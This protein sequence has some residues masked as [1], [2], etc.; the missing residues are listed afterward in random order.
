MMNQKAERLLFVPFILHPV[1]SV[2]RNDIRQISLFLN[3]IIILSNKIRIII[4]SLTRH[5]FPIIKTGR[6]TFQVP[7]TYQSCL[8]THLLKQLRKSLLC[9]I[10]NTGSVIIKFIGTT[11]LTGYHAG[12]A[13]STQWIS[14]KTIGKAYSVISDTIQIGS[15]HI[16]CIIA[17][18]H[19]SCMVVCHDI[20]NIIWF[21]FFFLLMLTRRSCCQCC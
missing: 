10:K 2:I 17:T 9:T 3:G 12:T 18:H 8:V 21:C 1:D 7:F 11:M 13:R 14:H 15:F 6:Q 20:N 5:D 4:I 16:T 19:L